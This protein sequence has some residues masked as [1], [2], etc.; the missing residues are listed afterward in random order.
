MPNTLDELIAVVPGLR[1]ARR[2]N[3][4]VLRILLD[5]N[6]GECTWC[7]TIVKSPRRTWCSDACSNHFLRRCGNPAHYVEQRDKGICR[8]CGR[9]TN[10]CERVWRFLQWAANNQRV[11]WREIDSQYADV[12]LLLG[13]GRGRWR[14]VDHDPPVIEG[15]GLCDPDQL[16]LLC[17]VCHADETKKLAKRRSKG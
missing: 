7:G 5:R 16:R 15:G 17:G 4:D 13:F 14:E 11:S 2:L 3:A 8:L 6:R 9:D 10:K 12:K 1:R